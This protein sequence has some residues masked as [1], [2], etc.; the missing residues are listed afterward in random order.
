MN[1]DNDLKDLRQHLDRIDSNILRLLDE[2]LLV[3][4][5]MAN[6][7]ERLGLPL[8]SKEREQAIISKLRAQARHP[9]LREAI[10]NIF[11]PILELSKT[12][13]AARRLDI[14]QKEAPSMTVG[15]IGYGRFG[16]LMADV[17]Q[18]HWPR[19]KVK[20]CSRSHKPD[21]QLFF[22]LAEVAQCDIIVPCMPISAL[23]TVLRELKPLLGV[24]STII[25]ICSVKVEPVRWLKEILG[26]AAQIIASHPMFGPDSTRH[27]TR[28]N[29]LSMVLHNISAPAAIY[30]TWAG[31]WQKLGVT[32]IDLTPEEH[33][34]LAASTMTYSFLI[35]RVSELVGIHRTPIDTKAFEHIYESM[36][37]IIHDSWELFCDIQKYNPYSAEIRKKVAAALETIEKKLL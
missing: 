14:S 29:G 1:S 22:S 16:S 21:G 33:D 15:I 30:E 5:K 11:G 19:A 2:R 10:I 6:V 27:G 17:L 32:I 26:P 4:Q 7:K 35:G 12:V 20:V 3:S 25:D 28:F 34:R 24:K 9:E 8:Y 31:F 13:Q 37:Y 36:E 23:P 18:K